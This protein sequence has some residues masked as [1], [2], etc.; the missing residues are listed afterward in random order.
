ML[1]FGPLGALP[2]GDSGAAA[3]GTQTLTPSLFTNSQTFYSATVT[4]GAVTLTPVFKATWGM[5][6]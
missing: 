1:G 3:G 4:P 2:L 6:E 5:S